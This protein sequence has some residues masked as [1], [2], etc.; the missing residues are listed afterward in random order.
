MPSL[1]CDE[2]SGE[3]DGE[4]EA[5][6]ADPMGEEERGLFLCEPSD[7]QPPKAEPSPSPIDPPATAADVHEAAHAD[8]PTVMRQEAAPSGASALSVYACVDADAW[9]SAS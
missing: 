5:A 7:V 8:E 1:T 9:F 2:G 3:G 4:G 6:A